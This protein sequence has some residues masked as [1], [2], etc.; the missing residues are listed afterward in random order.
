VVGISSSE[1]L[2]LVVLQDVVLATIVIGIF[3]AG[4]FIVRRLGRPVTY[5]LSALG[6]S[7]PR[8]GVLRGV[9]LGI[10]TGLAA[11]LIEIVAN[12][13]SVMVL[14]HFGYSARST[15]Q[16]PFMRGLE[17]WVRQSPEIAIP[18]MVAVVVLFGPAVEELVFRGAVFNGL[19]RLGLFLSSRAGPKNPQTGSRVSFGVAAVISS[20]LFSLLHLEPVVFLSIFILALLL[21]SVFARTG[22]LLTSFAAH[23]TFNSLA[24]VVIILDGLGVLNLPV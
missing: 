18:A 13:V 12:P 4:V 14:K 24:V 17:G 20:I 22:S 2:L 10:G 15:V 8:N 21:C 1:T 16:Q 3:F 19:Y 23:A 6:L 7:R 5:S 9:G 11:I